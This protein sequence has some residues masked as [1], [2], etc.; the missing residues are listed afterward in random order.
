M[1]IV[2]KKMEFKKDLAV[3]KAARFNDFLSRIPQG[4]RI[5]DINMFDVDKRQTIPKT[6]LSKP[7]AKP[8][9]EKQPLMQKPKSNFSAK[10]KSKNSENE[11]YIIPV[12]KVK[13]DLKAAAD[14]EKMFKLLF[15]QSVQG[16]LVE[17][18]LANCPNLHKRFFGKYVLDATENIKGVI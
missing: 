13:D 3:P 10:E 7:V 12:K 15:K 14:A 18:L 4:N 11:R 9:V 5:N 6:S 8:V 1:S 17:D 16:I 2:K